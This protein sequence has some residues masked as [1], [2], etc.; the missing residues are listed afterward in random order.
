M[1]YA[2]ARYVTIVPEIDMP[3]H[4]NAALIAHPE[5]SCSSRAPV[6]YSG[7]DV[8]WSTLC[9]D[10]E[11]TYAFVEDVVREL[12]L[13]TPGPWLHVGGDEVRGLTAEQYARFVERVQ[14]IVTKHGKRMIGWEEIAAAKLAPTSVAQQ[15]ATD[16]AIKAIRYGAKLILSPAKK[17]YLDMKYTPSTE[18]GLHWA[19]YVGVR[20]AYDWNP[21]AYLPGVVEGNVLGVEAAIWSETLRNIT[22]VEYMAMPRLP[23]IAEVA[24]SPQRTRDWENFRERLANHAPRWH[25]LGVNY[26]RS[27]EVSW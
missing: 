6:P 9:V 25:L 1:R 21:A 18:L 2:Q 24:W 26:F 27:P 5:L 7:T 12:A 20:D 22:A 16:S 19:G 10:K 23:A 17:V 14:Q 15:W 13:L 3:G 11:E 4:S 8:G